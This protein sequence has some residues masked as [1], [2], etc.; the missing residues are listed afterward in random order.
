MRRA[1]VD[2]SFTATGASGDVKP[3]AATLTQLWKPRGRRAGSYIGATAGVAGW[4]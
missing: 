2:R 4:T 3:P 1:N